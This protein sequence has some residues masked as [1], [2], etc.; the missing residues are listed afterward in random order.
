[1][2]ALIAL[3]KSNGVYRPAASS[4][5][6]I[7]ATTN[8]SRTGAIGGRAPGRKVAVHLFHEP[9]GHVSGM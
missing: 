6:D 5:C 4:E 3:V 1:L 7:G 8:Q 2:P 9:I